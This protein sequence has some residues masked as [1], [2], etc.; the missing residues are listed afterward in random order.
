MEQIVP[1][2][3]NN[4]NFKGKT[5]KDSFNFFDYKKRFSIN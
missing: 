1:S 5:T 4:N 3:I 2:E